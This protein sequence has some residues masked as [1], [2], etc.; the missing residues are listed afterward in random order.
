MIVLCCVRNVVYEYMKRYFLKYFPGVDVIGCNLF[1]PERKTSELLSIEDLNSVEVELFVLVTENE[2]EKTI[3]KKSLLDWGYKKEKIFDFSKLYQASIPK[4][5]IDRLMYDWDGSAYEGIIFGISHAEVGIV[6]KFMEHKF[7]N[8]ALSHQDLYYN[9]CTLKYLIEKYP[10]SVEKL[11]HVVI[12][13]FDYTYFNYDTSLSENAGQYYLIGGYNLDGHNFN[14]NK[15][16]EYHF[17]EIIQKIQ[18]E[19]YKEISETEIDVWEKLFLNFYEYDCNRK[20]QQIEMEKRNHIVT[21]SEIACM[22][23]GS[24]LNNVFSQTIEENLLIFDE[25]IKTLY[26][27]NPDMKIHVVL[28]PRYGAVEKSEEEDPRIQNWKKTFLKLLN[29]EKKKYDFEFIDLKGVNEIS[30]KREYYQDTSHL[31]ALGA[32]AMT[33]YI[34]NMIYENE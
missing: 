8:V 6:T 19:W 33:T 30:S 26:S 11:Q 5:N 22:G 29:M 31:N 4:L 10:Q 2:T 16:F 3:I 18:K 24:I 32:Y 20:F 23:Y 17:E 14:K 7:L 15:N 25:F 13:M 21:D 1:F 28:L 9:L 12:D 34:E 27:L